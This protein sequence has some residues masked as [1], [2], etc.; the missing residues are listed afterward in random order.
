MVSIT[1]DG[2]IRS[3][4]FVGQTKTGVARVSFILESHSSDS[5]PL[6][7]SIICLGSTTA[8]RAAT[9]TRGTRILVCGRLTSGG[10][11]KKV[12]VIA[13]HFELLET[14]NHDTPAQSQITD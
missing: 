13:S 6:H 1:L 8:G 4:V 7:F 12:S 9:L 2:T 10:K 14:V 5:L 11:D 3:E